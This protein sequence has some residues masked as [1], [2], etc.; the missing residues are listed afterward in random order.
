MTEAAQKL[1]KVGD[2]S[3]GIAFNGGYSFLRLALKEAS[4]VKIFEEAKAEVSGAFQEAEGKRLET[5]YLNKLK[6]IYKP[7]YFYENLEQAYKS[8]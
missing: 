1:K 4:R 8:E 3:E 5:E 7:V 2:V 6:T